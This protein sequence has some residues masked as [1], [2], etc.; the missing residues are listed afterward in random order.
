MPFLIFSIVFTVYSCIPRVETVI[1][2]NCV[3]EVKQLSFEELLARLSKVHSIKGTASVELKT[4]EKVLSGD[5][6]LKIDGNDLELKTYSVGVQAGELSQKSG[7]IYSDPKLE[8]YE[9]V[10]FINTIRNG[11]F[12]WK[13]NNRKTQKGAYLIQIYNSKRHTDIDRKTLLP[14]EQ[15][16][17]LENGYELTIKY[18]QVFCTEGVW[19]PAQI[20]ASLEGLRISIEFDGVKLGMKKKQ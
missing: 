12:W 10:F 8:P 20:E 6:L 19:F 15:K 11:L 1:E 9:E 14:M 18:K 7:V 4:P 5:A 2:P 17:R 13:L 16:I 3:K